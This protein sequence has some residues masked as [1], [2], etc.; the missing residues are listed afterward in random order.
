M[1]FPSSP[2]NGQVSIV[3]GITYVY[4]STNRT[5]TRQAIQAGEKTTTS[6]TAPLNPGPG[7][8]WYNSTNDTIL[9]YMYDGSNWWWIDRD[10]PT[11]TLG[12]GNTI[13]GNLSVAGNL[14]VTGNIVGGTANIILQTFSGNSGQFFGNAAGF[15]ALYAGI[16]SGYSA[17]P[18]TI[19]QS[20]GNFNSYV[21]NNSQ[22]INAGAQ[23][24]TDWVATASNGTD[25]IYYVDLGIAGGGYANTSPS[26]SLGTS[27]WPNDAYLYAQGNVAG[28]PGGNLVVGTSIPGTVTRILAGGVNSANVVATFANT[29][30]TINGNL[31]VNNNI[32]LSNG[33]ANGIV[34]LNSANVLTTGTALVFTGTNV[35]VGTTN[36]ASQLHLNF[37]N[38]APN[39][40]TVGNNSN[41]AIFGAQS[42]GNPVI[43]SYT[44]AMPIQLGYFSGGIATTFTEQARLNN[45]G[46]LGIG[47][48]SPTSGLSL[49]LP[50]STGGQLYF[51]STGS[52]S[53]GNAGG[54]NTSSNGDKIVFYNDAGSSYDGRIG[55]G[56]SSNLWLKS[57][58]TAG[59]MIQ[60]ITGTNTTTPSMTLNSGAQLGINT[61]T[62]AGRLSSNTG[63]TGTYVTIPGNLTAWD[64]TVSVFG[65]AG[66]TT[67]AAVGIGMTSSGGYLS[68]LAPAVSWQAMYYNA[69]SHNWCYSATQ[70]ASLSSAGTLTFDVSGQ[71]IQ[72]TNSSALTDSVLNDY[73]VGTWTPGLTG[74]G[75]TGSV[76]VSSGNYGW[77]VKVGRVV[78]VGGTVTWSSIS[79]SITG[80]LQITG[81]PFASASNGS[82]R[83][84]GSFG[85][86]PSSVVC[87]SSAYGQIQLVVDPGYSFAWVLAQNSTGSY[88]QTAFTVASSGNIYG[89]GAT[90][91]ANF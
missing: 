20:A 86:T 73:E 85:V 63:A 51:Q 2:S 45:N 42:A 41:G 1:A 39:A 90:Y 28:Q 87:T 44:G 54:F 48:A 30:A 55:V 58:G 84:W 80:A 70:L 23:S 49:N 88:T 67:G 9:T 74:T 77:Y 4:S 13:N 26:N 60:F 22:N 72:F 25:T 37:A 71:G 15:G 47:T 82:G 52:S 24:T 12:P 78:H 34:Y 32:T 6:A 53:Y 75:A 31:V 81:L 5:W 16:P 7:D 18:D 89:F 61:T 69:S 27:L 68:S 59:G 11:A 79:G 8:V 36:P 38:T 91:I 66:S 33:T 10:G 50:G 40:L 76:V 35:G 3:N 62:P 57:L 17:T 64:S 83:N 14:T 29:G 65:N 56:S 21:Q 43:G 46:Y 19:I